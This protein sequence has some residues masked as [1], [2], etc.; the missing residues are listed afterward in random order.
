MAKQ[1]R[2]WILYSSCITVATYLATVMHVRLKLI[3]S[4]NKTPQAQAVLVLGG[5]HRREIAAAQ[6]A[7]Q[8]SKLTIW[9]SSGIS[10]L[11]AHEIFRTKAVPLSRVILDYTATDTVT[12]F[13]TLVNQLEKNNIQHIYLIT[14][15]FHMP[16]AKSIAFWVLGSR[17]IAYTPVSVPSDE[18]FEPFHKTLRDVTR[19]WLWLL[20]GRTGSSLDPNPPTKTS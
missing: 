9:V 17:G 14:S 8:E 12:N 19:S 11:Q 4:S 5:N 7:A 10:E 20:T 3:I 13:T 15:D 2:Q 16:R 1:W 6:L 18:P